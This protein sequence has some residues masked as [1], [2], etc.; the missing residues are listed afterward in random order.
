MS[1]ITLKILKYEFNE[2]D[3]TSN[4]TF[5]LI[6]GE[7]NFGYYL[8]IP[9]D[10]ISDITILKF[11]NKNIYDILKKIQIILKNKEYSFKTN[12]GLKKL[13][14]WIMVLVSQNHVF[15]F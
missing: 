4:F 10:P 12:E 7:N 11:N 6:I 14:E 9:S 8:S 1:N 15:T 13:H 3:V 5:D 2:T